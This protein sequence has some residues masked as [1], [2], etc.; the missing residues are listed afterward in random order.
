M[1]RR[2]LVAIL[3][4]AVILQSGFYCPKVAVAAEKQTIAFVGLYPLKTSFERQLT[5]EILKLLKDDNDYLL[6]AKDSVDRLLAKRKRAE[7]QK[8]S[9]FKSRLTRHLK[10]AKS[11][12]DNLNFAK[13]LNQL[14]MAQALIDSRFHLLR[15]QKQLLKLHLY[16]A[17]NLIASKK[18]SSAR[19]SFIDLLR[20][21]VTRHKR[22]LNPRNFPPRILKVF[23]RAKKYVLSQEKAS[24]TISGQPLGARVYL[25]GHLLGPLPQTIK[26]LPLGDH[27]LA[28]SKNGYQL[29][30]KRLYVDVGSN[31]VELN[32]EEKSYFPIV[33]SDQ[34]LAEQS[35]KLQKIAAEVGSDLLLLAQFSDKQGYQLAGQLF[36]AASGEYSEVV[37]IEQQSRRR[38][39]SSLPGWLKS[40]AEEKKQAAQATAPISEEKLPENL[41]KDNDSLGDELAGRHSPLVDEDQGKPYYKKL[42]FWGAV[43][44]VVAG[45]VA[46]AYFGGIFSKS[47]KGDPV[48]VVPNPGQ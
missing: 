27:Y 3:C 47:E 11:F 9:I 37:T 12:Y 21:D 19:N 43:V 2:G 26:K 6:T 14:E 35:G 41:V 13:S 1:F 17:M 40:L 39:L 29:F 44:A 20:Y 23:A 38:L 5:E 48:I 16:R 24:V 15:S 22:R 32:L 36:S 33:G 28:V 30:S 10:K 25:D 46:G 31:E 34:L 7:E 45:G 18:I 8:F 42:W 4:L